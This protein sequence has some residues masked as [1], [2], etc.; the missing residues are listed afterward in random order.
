MDALL[1]A[2]ALITIAGS[3]VL[4]V[5]L[6]KTRRALKEAEAERD[7][8]WHMAKQAAPL[9]ALTAIQPENRAE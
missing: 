4:G 2:T 1:L 3:T 7:R 8:Y 5:L 6:A 9:V